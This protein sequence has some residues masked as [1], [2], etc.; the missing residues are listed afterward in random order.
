MLTFEKNIIFLIIKIQLL[1]HF[2]KLQ[3]P[4]FKTERR[5]LHQTRLMHCTR[6]QP[7]PEKTKKTIIRKTGIDKSQNTDLLPL[8]KKKAYKEGNK[9]DSTNE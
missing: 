4:A 5:M 8:Q 3:M 9:D 1:C 7:Q 6:R 2:Q